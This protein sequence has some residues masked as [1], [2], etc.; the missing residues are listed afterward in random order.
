MYALFLLEHILSSGIGLFFCFV[1]V[2]CGW[3]AFEWL[4]V[5]FCFT[6]LATPGASQNSVQPRLL[7]TLNT[8]YQR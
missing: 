6:D 8:H 2:F 4:F 5:W 3:A 1:F 7:K